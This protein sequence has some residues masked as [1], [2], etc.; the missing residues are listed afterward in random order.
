MAI[1]S[2]GSPFA[3]RPISDGSERTAHLVG[4]CGSGMRA[5]AE[6][7]VD[8]G[9][10]VSGSDQSPESRARRALRELGVEVGSGHR[11]DNI[12]RDVDLV[13]HSAA[14]P[15]SNVERIAAAGIGVVDLSY[16]QAIGCLTQSART[17]AIA[18]THGKTT[19]AAM[20]GWVLREAGW[21][22]SL[23]CGGELR[24]LNRAGWR[25]TGD[26]LVLEACEYGRHFLQLRPKHVA[27]LSIEP[28]HFDC[29]PDLD[30][31]I[32][33]YREFLAAV[34]ANGSVLLSADAPARDQLVRSAKSR[35]ES[36]GLNPAD[37]WCAT[38]IGAAER[39]VSF[40]LRHRGQA[41]GRV[42]LSHP[43]RHNVANAAAA[44][45]LAAQLG[46]PASAVVDGLRTFPGVRRRFE[47]H[48]RPGDVIW[49]DDYAHHPTAVRA[50]LTAARDELGARRVWC[51]FQ[52]HQVSRTVSLMSEFAAS[53][54]LADEVLLLPVYA[55]RESA[56]LD[57]EEPVR[58]LAGRLHAAG[59]AARLEATLD[60]VAATLETEPRPG[61][62]VAV[63]GAGDIERVCNEFTG[64]VR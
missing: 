51:A 44:A 25:G 19:T 56:E 3:E 13:V 16:P 7:L 5:L 57:R 63:L 47:L 2:A 8:A 12:P 24:G 33:S 20:L 40:T 9:W 34:P 14:V 17:V 41:W 43:G 37:D 60:R 38:E 49:V 31:A 46:V 39:R 48:E 22:A 64:R 36:C 10:R 52:P 32:H 4:A 45:A 6:Y 23:I 59:C 26:L 21:N 30:S 15:E 29:Y 11:A 1:H 58:R 42:E 18:G 50:V 55:A 27:V 28:D 53:L 35:V 54:A 61:D 62:V